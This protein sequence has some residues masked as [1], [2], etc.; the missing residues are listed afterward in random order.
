MSP[1]KKYVAVYE[2]DPEADAWNVRIEGE[3]GCQTYGRSLRQ[4]QTRIRDA[5]ALWLD[6]EPEDLT[7]EDRLPTSVTTV[8]TQVARARQAAEVAGEKAQKQT[9][10]AVKRLTD[11]G[12]SRR[13]A[14]DVLGLS[15]QRVQQLVDAR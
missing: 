15:H 1:K 7:I 5:L 10:E 12:L 9:T 6:R 3:P 8:A 2:R 14:A 11:L 4:A 13:D